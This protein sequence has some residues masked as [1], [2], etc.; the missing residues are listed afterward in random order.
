[1]R[2]FTEKLKKHRQYYGKQSH[3]PIFEHH[4]MNKTFWYVSKL[5]FTF[6]T[7]PW[8]LGWL[9]P[10]KFPIIKTNQLLDYEHHMILH[11][12]KDSL[13]PDMA[14]F[15][16]IEVLISKDLV[17]VKSSDFSHMYVGWCFD[18]GSSGLFF[19]HVLIR[20]I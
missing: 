15:M 13:N 2:N 17:Y 18:G 14:R 6:T 16:L 20:W 5:M 10:E 3:T 4:C 11:Y 8:L 7:S 19:Y 9:G 12:W 1:M